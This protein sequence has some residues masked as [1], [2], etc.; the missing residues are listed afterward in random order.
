VP[1]VP[2]RKARAHSPPSAASYS[3]PGQST[4]PGKARPRSWPPGPRRT[5]GEPDPRMQRGKLRCE[6]RGQPWWGRPFSRCSSVRAA[7]CWHRT[8]TYGYSGSIRQNTAANWI[9]G[10]T[11]WGTLRMR[12]LVQQRSGQDGPRGA[13][14]RAPGQ[15]PPARSGLRHRAWMGRSSGRRRNARG[16]EGSRS[17]MG[18][19]SIGTGP[20]P[21]ARPGSQ[22]LRQGW[23]SASSSCCHR[24]GSRRVNSHSRQPRLGL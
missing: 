6:R 1:V 24:H 19:R 2:G 17:A 16:G 3:G 14:S 21:R 12:G 18:R 13:R 5:T 23:N 11:N 20:R 22:G 10:V 9:A 7:Q 4:V 8:R 15:R